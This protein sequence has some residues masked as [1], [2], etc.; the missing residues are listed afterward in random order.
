VILLAKISAFIDSTMIGR[1][2]GMII[3]EVDFEVRRLGLSAG[4]G[5]YLSLTQ[6]GLFKNRSTLTHD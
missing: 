6:G 5:H 1:C 4:W 2:S 3:D